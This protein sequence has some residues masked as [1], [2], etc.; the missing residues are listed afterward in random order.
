M[1]V[2]GKGSPIRAVLLQIVA[3]VFSIYIAS[4]V[5]VLSSVLD[6]VREA[7]LDAAVQW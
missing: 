6:S 2:S 3:G 4:S 5:G 1:S 7:A